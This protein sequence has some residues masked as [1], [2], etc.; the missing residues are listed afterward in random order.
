[1]MARLELDAMRQ[2]ERSTFWAMRVLRWRASELLVPV[3]V[4]LLAAGSDHLFRRGF[5]QPRRYP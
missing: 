4:A 1:M 5:G 3:G 2:R